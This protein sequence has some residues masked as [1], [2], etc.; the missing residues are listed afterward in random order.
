MVSETIIC[1]AEMFIFISTQICKSS[2]EFKIA[3]LWP[4][5]GVTTG[6][7]EPWPD[8][9]LSVPESFNYLGNFSPG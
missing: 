3:Q 5:G 8:L 6:R 9:L 2:V 4:F 1:L 7:Q